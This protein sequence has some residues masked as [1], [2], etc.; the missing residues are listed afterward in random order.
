[1]SELSPPAIENSTKSLLRDWV[2][3]LGNDGIDDFEA[4]LLLRLDWY[5]SILANLPES[6]Q[7]LGPMAQPTPV[8]HPPHNS[9]V[10][11]TYKNICD[12]LRFSSAKPESKSN[13]Q[14]RLWPLLWWTSSFGGHVE[15]IDASAIAHAVTHGQ[16]TLYELV[17]FLVQPDHREVAHNL[18]SAV[19]QT[20]RMCLG[21]D[22]N[23]DAE[24]K[25]VV[26]AV[27]DICRSQEHAADPSLPATLTNT[28]RSLPSPPS[29]AMLFEVL[30]KYAQTTFQVVGSTNDQQKMF[31]AR[32]DEALNR[33][34]DIWLL[35]DAAQRY[36]A[37]GPS[38]STK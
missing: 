16:A 17:W 14:Q 28:W 38:T 9:I 5:E 31:V 24:I 33:E 27:A 12:Y 30:E 13:I 22:A 15:N 4:E 36:R 23:K 2:R 21:I 25:S 8:P 18:V 34:S 35:P 10:A 7:Q 20:E 1:M 6:I 32:L 11:Y 37:K 19:E 3:T 29:R 26:A